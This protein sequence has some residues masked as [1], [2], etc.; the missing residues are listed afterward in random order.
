MKNITKDI[1]YVGV[2]DHQVDL[3]EGQYVVPNGMAYN[4]YVIKDEVIAIMDTVDQNF[5][6]EWLNNISQVL[7]DEKPTYLVLQWE[8]LFLGTDKNYIDGILP[9]EL[10]TEFIALVTPLKSLN[11]HLRT[12]GRYKALYKFTYPHGNEFYME[13]ETLQKFVKGVVRKAIIDF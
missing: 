10:L 4:S 9:T 2:N 1:F 12:D 6:D 8:S 7:G 11:E 13:L 5:T 3:F